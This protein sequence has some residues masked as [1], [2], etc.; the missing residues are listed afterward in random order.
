MQGN[1][2]ILAQ[3]CHT[4]EGSRV[5]IRSMNPG[6]DLSGICMPPYVPDMILNRR[7]ERGY[8]CEE[9]TTS[10]WDGRIRA[11]TPPGRRGASSMRILLTCLLAGALMPPLLAQ[12]PAP[13]A[14]DEAAV[15][16]VI[17]RYMAARDARDPAAVEAL[18]TS[19]ADQLTTSGEWRRGRDQIRSGT[20]DSSRRNP[21]ERRI[22]IDT[23]RF[24]TPD[25]AIVDGPYAITAAG[26]ASAR[27]M[28][29]T[30]VLVR[31]AG[32]WRISAIRNMVPAG[33][34]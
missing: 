7:D 4:A 1:G 6:V 5:I 23:V 3:A 24:V 22:S 32:G 17:A 26:A 18:F 13:A 29:T 27:R 2:R 9:N 19:D 21:G 30:I 28:W 11:W 31:T 12:Q 16:D 34:Q 20:A 10:L 33:G 15:R 8:A 25:V 14:A